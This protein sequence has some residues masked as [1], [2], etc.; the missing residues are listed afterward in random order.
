MQPLRSSW[1][2]QSVFIAIHPYPSNPLIN[3]ELRFVHEWIL[4]K[5]QQISCRPLWKLEILPHLTRPLK[6]SH[7]AKPN[8]AAASIVQPDIY[9]GRADQ[10]CVQ[11]PSDKKMS[12]TKV[13]AER[14]DSA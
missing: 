2:A 5:Y 8:K 9:A 13:S 6:S 14:K 4:N 10:R 3:T 11:E 1:H 7:D 12:G